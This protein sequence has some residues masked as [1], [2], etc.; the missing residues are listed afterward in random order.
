MDLTLQP[1]LVATGEE[2]E[3]VLVFCNGR[4]VAILV[5]LSDLHEEQAGWWFLETGFGPLEGPQHPSF[6]D[7]D[8]ASAWM[9]ARLA[10]NPRTSLWP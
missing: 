3:G 2:G 1:V 7:L 9:K 10:G 5:R 8:G 6:P 4:L